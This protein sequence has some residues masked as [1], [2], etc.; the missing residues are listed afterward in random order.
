M[1][2]FVVLEPYATMI[3]DGLKSWELR[4]RRPPASKVGR[5]IYLLSSGEILGVVKIASFSGPLSQEDLQAHFPEHRVRG[6]KPGQYAWKLEVVR[7]FA[8]RRRYLHP[9]GARIWLKQVRPITS[10]MA[11]KVSPHGIPS[12]NCDRTRMS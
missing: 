6:P 4:S 9:R 1:D 11:S 5:R 8:R 10:T 7:R 3:I 2:G 12:Q